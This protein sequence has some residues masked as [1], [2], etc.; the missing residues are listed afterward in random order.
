MN[1]DRAN[2]PLHSG[3]QDLLVQSDEPQR[4]LKHRAK[5]L[6]LRVNGSEAD[7]NLFACISEQRI[8]L[9]S[10]PKIHKLVGKIEQKQIV[11]V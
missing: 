2:L 4:A 5:L 3:M 11:C 9:T 1:S 10:G 8:K 7:N 6:Q